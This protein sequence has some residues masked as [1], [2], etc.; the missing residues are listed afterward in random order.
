M[1]NAKT[2]FCFYFI[3]HGAIK[4]V[5]VAALLGRKLRAYPVA[6]AFFALFAAYQVYRYFYSHAVLMLVLT[7]FDVFVIIFA[8]LEYKKLR[9]SLKTPVS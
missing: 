3:S 6:I 8:W 2:F 7:A 9:V 5:L 1:T 4:L